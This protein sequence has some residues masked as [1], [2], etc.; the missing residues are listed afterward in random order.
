ML[1]IAGFV[2]PQPVMYDVYTLYT[3]YTLMGETRPQWVH[4]A[5]LPPALAMKM[6]VK[7]RSDGGVAL[8]RKVR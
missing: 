8:T 4:L 6:L 3:G 1:K 2:S 5:C 7:I